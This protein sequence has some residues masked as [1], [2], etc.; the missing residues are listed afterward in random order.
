MRGMQPDDVYRLTGA[1]DPRLSPDGATVAYVVSWVDEDEHDRR[2]AIWAA[3][4]DGSAPPR[5]LT[6]G[7][8]ARWLPPV[9]ARRSMARLHLGARR[10]PGAALRPAG[11][12][13]G[14]VAAA[15]VA[16]GGGST[17]PTGRPTARGSRSPRAPTI[18]PTTSR[19]WRSVRHAG[20]RGCSSG[21]T[22]R[23]GRRVARITSTWSASTAAEPMQLTDGDARRPDARVVARRRHDRV[24]VGASCGL[25]PRRPR[26]TLHDR[27]R[28]GASPCAMTAD[29]RRVA[30]LPVWSPDGATDRLR[31]RPG[32][33]RRS[34]ARHGSRSLDLAS[35]ARTVLTEALDRNAA[36]FPAIRAPIWDADRIVFAG[37]GRGARARCTRFRPTG[38]RRAARC[39]EA[40][41]LR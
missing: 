16:E 25:G 28:A 1:G 11:R 38:R 30:S 36:P 10:G 6:F 34:A 13:P 5:R 20:S 21:S 22:T 41:G 9:V 29:R 15:H 23:D 2:S 40:G 18:P 32:G 24:R 33:V 39:A 35:G 19:M 17:A 4:T 3:P 27:R 37:R 31:V 12:R 8:D 14:R 26:P 7:G